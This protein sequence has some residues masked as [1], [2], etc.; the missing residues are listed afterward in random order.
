MPEGLKL[1][2]VGEIFSL[3]TKQPDSIEP[4][5][6]F[7]RLSSSHSKRFDRV[8]ILIVVVVVD[9]VVVVVVDVDVGVGFEPSLLTSDN[10]RK[11]K[12]QTNSRRRKSKS[13]SFRFV[14][15]QSDLITIIPSK[16]SIAKLQYKG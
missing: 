12:G 7:H 1:H 16:G 10:S 9:V 4:P 14:A 3:S 13:A 15:E 5:N 2:R 8:V 11:F 6:P